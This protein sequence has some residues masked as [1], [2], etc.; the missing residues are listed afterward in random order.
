MID[1]RYHLVSLVSVFLAL[2]VGI[3]LG[4]GP[5]KESIGD[6]LTQ[7]VQS[8]RKEKDALRAELNTADAAINHR[9]DW[10]ASV[11]PLL[12]DGQLASRTVV[13]VVLP[14]VDGDT[15]KSV[16][17][18]LASAGAT[19]TGR[20]DIQGQWT[21]EERADFRDQ[22]ATQLS[23][24]VPVSITADGSSDVT[25]ARLA[26]LLGRALLTTSVTTSSIDAP[27]RTVLEALGG[28]DLIKVNGDITQRADGVVILAPANQPD[29]ATSTPTA[30]GALS[31]IDAYVALATA[32]DKA[33]SGTVVSGPASSANGGGVVAAVRSDGDVADVVSTV[34]NGGTPMGVVTD[35]L[36]MHE[37]FAGRSGSYGFGDGASA[38]VPSTAS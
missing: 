5:L 16:T 15:V 25:A 13:V 6:T 3:V 11:S 19:L 20:V 18:G 36:A 31:P 8:L 27:A 34:D 10:T 37:Q 29:N 1:F 38:P 21:D 28:G 9:D 24:T 7:Q 32:L 14:G 30:T 12:M 26:A 22:L 35:V 2:A 23:S 17:D 33:G 4:A